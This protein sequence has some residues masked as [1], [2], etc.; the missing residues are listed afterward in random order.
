M[1]G[2]TLRT[3]RWAVTLTEDQSAALVIRVWLEGGADQFRARLTTAEIAGS[4]GR[5]GNRTLAASSPGDVLDAVR[6]WL[7]EFLRHASDSIDST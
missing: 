7:D 3:A 4:S 6:E 5:G 2:I 1:I